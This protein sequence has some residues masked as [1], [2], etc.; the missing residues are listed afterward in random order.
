MARLYRGTYV[1][2]N[3]SSTQCDVKQCEAV[4]SGLQFMIRGLCDALDQSR[5]QMLTAGSLNGLSVV[6]ET[7]SSNLTPS[8]LRPPSLRQPT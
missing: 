7:A 2:F 4:S 3:H 1:K 6:I 8:I 5:H